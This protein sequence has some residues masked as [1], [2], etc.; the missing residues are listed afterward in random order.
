[1]LNICASDRLKGE[2][3]EAS[4]YVT[5]KVT[6]RNLRIFGVPIL[7]NFNDLLQRLEI[8]SPCAGYSLTLRSRVQ[9]SRCLGSLQRL[10][11]RLC[12]RGAIMPALTS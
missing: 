6:Q 7:E 1:M 3:V 8:D 4:E 12:W 9:T 10:G 11:S 5:Q 2:N